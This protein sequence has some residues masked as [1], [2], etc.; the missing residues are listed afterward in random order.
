MNVFAEGIIGYDKNVRVAGVHNFSF[1]AP[2]PLGSSL[3]LTRVSIFDGE[4]PSVDL[5]GRLRRELFIDFRHRLGVDDGA[6]VHVLAGPVIIDFSG[7]RK[8]NLWL[9]VVRDELF[10]LVDRKDEYEWWE[11]SGEERELF[12]S[13]KLTW[14]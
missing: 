2:L 5:F 6:W 1:Y 11:L 14:L 10:S 7:M 12:N 8:R 3:K 4:L 13:R 9:H